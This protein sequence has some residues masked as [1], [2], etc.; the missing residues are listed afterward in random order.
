M[1]CGEGV[2]LAELRLP[3][4]QSALVA[5]VAATGTRSSWSW[6][7][8]DRTPCPNCPRGPGPCSAPGT[9]ARGRARRRGRPLRRRPCVGRLPVSVP[10]SSA[11]LPVHYNART[12]ATAATSTSPPP[13]STP[14]ATACR[15]R[16]STTARRACP[17][18][19]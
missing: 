14:S 10:R 7:R 11:Q 5:A 6:C 19:G 1:T 16:P 13:P 17:R 4:A 2:D 3:P 9:R 12:T 8:A 18:G 15:T